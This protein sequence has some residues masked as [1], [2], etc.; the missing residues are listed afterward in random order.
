MTQIG[1][2]VFS[3]FCATTVVLAQP[4]NDAITTDVLAGDGNLEQ[5]LE[6][7]TEN[8]WESTQTMAVPEKAAISST[9][10]PVIDTNKFVAIGYV[11][12]S[13]PVDAYPWQ[14]MT[15]LAYLFT[16]FDANGVITNP[17][18]WN[19]RKAA[20]QPGGTAD[21]YGVKVL[22]CLRNGGF[23]DTIMTTVMNS[24]TL[25]TTLVKN[26][27]EHIAAGGDNCAGV[28]LDLEPVAGVRASAAGITEFLK[29]MKAALGEKELSLY[30]SPTYYTSFDVAGWMKSCDYLIYSCYPFVGSWSTN[31]GPVA[32]ESTYDSRVDKY[33]LN[34]CPPEKL[35]LA[36]PS[37]G[38]QTQ[39]TESGY[40]TTIEEHVGSMGFTQGKWNTTLA[41][42]KRTRQY[43]EGAEAV[44]YSYQDGGKWYVHNYDDEESLAHKVRGAQ[45]WVGAQASGHRLRGVAYWSMRWMGDNPANSFKSYDME[46]GEMVS[47]YRYYPHICQATQETLAPEGT[48]SF[49][50]EKWEHLEARWRDPDVPGVDNIGSNGSSIQCVACPTGT[51]KPDNSAYCLKLYYSFASM[52]YGNRLFLR[53]EILGHHTENTIA[54]R[55]APKALFSKNMTVSVDVYTPTAYPNQ[56]VRFVIMD[57]KGELE[58]SSQHALN[59]SGWRT[60]SFDLTRDPVSG[61]VTNFK[62]FK[63]GD[64]VLDTA[65]GGAYDL[66][67]VGFLVEGSGAAGSGYIYFDELRYSRTLPPH[68][69]YVINEF[70]SAQTSLQFV[71]IYGAAGT[72]PS[73]LELRFVGGSD[74]ATYAT[75]P[76]GGRQVANDGGGYGYYVV[77]SSA[78]PNVDFVLA[79]GAIENGTPSAIQ[80][81]DT[82]SGA[83][84]DAV[85]YNAH[86]GLAGLGGHGDPQVTQF[87]SPWVGGSGS[88]TGSNGRVYSRGRA[89]DGANTWN[90]SADLSVM[91]ATPG[92]TNVV[93]RQFPMTWNFTSVPA[94]ALQTYQTLGVVSPT[95]VGTS[96]SG[97]K[98]Y[99]C[100]DTTGGGIQAFFGGSDLDASDEGY[101]VT[102]EVYIP[103]AS[104]PAQAIGLGLCG[105]QGNSFFSGTTASGAYEDGYWLIFENV[106]G[107]GLNN[108]RADHAGVFEFVCAHNDNTR[109]TPVT[110]LGSKSLAETGAAGGAWT[111]FKMCIYP[112]AAAGEQLCVEVNGTRIYQGALPTGG[113][114]KGAFQVGFR[115]NHSGSPSAVEGTWIDNLRI[116]DVPSMVS[117]W[118]LY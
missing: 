17:S 59:D 14:A 92:A 44:W 33:I 118:E 64:G 5:T 6:F 1:P 15:H 101:T 91:Q 114:T 66:A 69:D 4:Q 8:S 34:G 97:G 52:A 77:G 20:F 111:T 11:Q 36:L 65:G 75:V 57:A 45:S 30:V 108:G 99:R 12:T 95:A 28:S 39:N 72:F 113:P 104:Q 107:V 55:N 88:G 84:C 54:D 87:G 100:C 117:G 83:V 58:I 29:E 102:G 21:R 51:N 85:V 79:N 98:V 42:A 86:D 110:L 19:N 112:N 50:I 63:S 10:K 94:C 115:E 103:S 24:P 3:L 13:T 81:Y 25:R 47:R 53:H 27:M 38:Y 18:T 37:Y 74:G 109:S 31:S 93:S 16:D 67:C 26:V 96:P 82:A 7:G 22:M 2:I 35:V 68:C 32:P 90:N 48:R 23:D 60:F 106:A 71:E 49:P 56:S 78:V 73:G 40:N 9:V 61:Y 70:S 76:L 80:L 46:A 105:R 89:V 41:P 62:S 43:I 116:N